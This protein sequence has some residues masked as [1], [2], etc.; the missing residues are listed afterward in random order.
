[1]KL[2]SY[3][4]V[5][6]E[7]QNLDLQKQALGVAGCDV[8]HVDKSTGADMKRRG[9][10][11]ALPHAEPGDVLAVWKRDR[12]S[13][14]LFDLVNLM[15]TPHDQEI[16]LKVLTGQGAMVDTTRPEGRFIFGIFAALAEFERELISERTRG[17][18]RRRTKARPAHG[19]ARKAHAASGGPCAGTDRFRKGN[20]GRSRR[21][22]QR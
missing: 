13:R 7:D 10:S 19:Q 2:I 17:R 16:G 15:R 4:R 3:A 21:A 12:L 1:M 20:T 18:H 5:S 11:K 22:A 14:S 6:T 9:L 8:I